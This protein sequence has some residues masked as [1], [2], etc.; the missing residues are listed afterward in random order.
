MKWY[1]TDGV[2]KNC[3]NCAHYGVCH[4]CYEYDIKMD[5]YQ[6]KYGFFDEVGE[7]SEEK[8]QDASQDSQAIPRPPKPPLARMCD[9]FIKRTAIAKALALPELLPRAKNTVLR[10]LANIMLYDCYSSVLLVADMPRF[11]GLSLYLEDT[12]WEHN[13][14]VGIKT[15]Q[16]LHMRMTSAM[17]EVHNQKSVFRLM[18]LK[19]EEWTQ[20]GYRFNTI[21]L[22]WKIPKNT[23]R[24]IGTEQSH[25]IKDNNLNTSVR[26]HSLSFATK[27]N[28][29]AVRLY[30]TDA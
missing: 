23:Q 19:P 8:S 12:V 20:N 21:I 18:Q 27:L 1:Y 26:D 28:I 4:M 7:E 11:K 24:R 13:K 16:A 15:P 10:E 30:D 6:T 25:W 3:Y 22:D 9:S 17:I 2:R 14:K 5:E 29:C